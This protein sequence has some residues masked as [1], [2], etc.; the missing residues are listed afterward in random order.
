MDIEYL[1]N[2]IKSGISIMPTNGKSPIIKGWTDLKPNEDILNKFN[3]DNNVG[4]I[5]GTNSGNLECL[6][7][8]DVFKSK[9]KDFDG[10]S[11]VFTQ[12]KFKEFGELLNSIDP[13]LFDKVIT[14]GLVTQTQGNGFHVWYKIDETPKDFGNHK[15]GD[16]DCIDERDGKIEINV[17]FETRGQGGQAVDFPSKGYNVLSGDFSKIPSISLASRNLIHDICRSFAIEAETEQQTQVQ[18]A[19]DNFDI[20]PGDDYNSKTDLNQFKNMLMQAGWQP[21]GTGIGKHGTFYKYTRP[22]GDKKSGDIS[23]TLNAVGN[24]PGMLY[25]FSSNEAKTGIPACRTLTP[26]AYLA[27]TEHNGNFREAAKRLYKEGYGSRK[28]NVKSL[29]DNQQN[30]EKENEIENTLNEDVKSIINPV[31]WEIY[32][33]KDEKT[34][35]KF[36]KYKLLQFLENNGW[37]TMY[38]SRKDLQY[39]RIEDNIIRNGDTDNKS[40]ISQFII[41]EMRKLP[42]DLCDLFSRDDAIAAF[43]ERQLKNIISTDYIN[44]LKPIKYNECKIRDTE[45]ESYVFYQNGALK[46]C[47]DV[48]GKVI[49]ELI[50]YKNITGLVNENEII[51]RDYVIT[52]DPKL[53]ERSDFYHYLK[54]VCSPNSAKDNEPE[55]R[56]LDEE[57]F[58][59]FKSAI[60]YLL[61]RFKDPTKAIAV[62][63]EE[64]QSGIFAD[65]ANGRTGKSLLSN[66]ISEIR[67]TDIID[68]KNFKKQNQFN[69]QNVSLNSNVVVLDDLPPKFDFEYLYSRITGKFEI[70]RKGRDIVSLPYKDAPKI[71]VSTNFVVNDMSNS[72]RDRRWELE[73]SDFYS[74]IRKPA[75]MTNG[76]AFFSD[77]WHEITDDENGYTQWQLFDMFMIDCIKHYLKNGVQKYALRNANAR[78]VQIN[79]PEDFITYAAGWLEKF[80]QGDGISNE[81]IYRGF[82]Q[83]V[84]EDGSNNMQ[85]TKTQTTK[86][87]R[88]V[89]EGAG[90]NQHQYIT[91]YWPPKGDK[92]IRGWKKRI[93][94]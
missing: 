25:S 76:V 38:D 2:V 68:A 52:D 20:S 90:F 89:I 21:A 58:N 35:I 42:E 43:L 56:I 48:E 87:M 27:Y 82:T 77:Y 12:T 64:E 39:V 22:G 62:I 19:I 31:F 26:F 75:D 57:R 9:N 84:R 61:H 92:S 74:D 14:N 23:A 11:S 10:K 88:H 66:A 80:K 24:K 85:I 60:G 13:A 28:K 59:S 17:V 65:D 36:D 67:K 69:F 93:I 44:N 55:N 73:F 30:K 51:K 5:C 63:F 6:D 53:F 46:V 32:V 29:N 72:G 3:A 47:F 94:I 4:Y 45:K 91:V 78:R 7:I 33:D 1:R 83:T 16:I 34:K 86:W 50:P 81:A 49:T 71:V 8:D 15:L 37:R 70:E 79:V 54:N 18:S 40:K 41:D